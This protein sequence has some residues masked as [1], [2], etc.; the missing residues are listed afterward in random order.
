MSFIIM[1]HEIIIYICSYILAYLA[2]KFDKYNFMGV[3]FPFV[4]GL[5]VVLACEWYSRST[6]ETAVAKASMVIS[7]A[8]GILVLIC[9]LFWNYHKKHN[10]CS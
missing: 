7:L 1:H 2:T 6:N 5:V 9:V 10:H 4:I 3:W 8:A